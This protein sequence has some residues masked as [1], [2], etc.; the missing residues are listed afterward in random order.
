M[1]IR[2]TEII[3]IIKKTSRQ[4]D[5]YLKVNSSLDV[6]KAIGKEQQKDNSS[7]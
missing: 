2:D 7:T 4:Y 5:E 3:A 6:L 1:E